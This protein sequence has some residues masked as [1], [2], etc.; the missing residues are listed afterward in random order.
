MR[1]IKFRAWDKKRNI[2]I[3]TS[4]PENWNDD[5]DEWYCDVDMMQMIGIENISNDDNFMLEQFTE[6]HLL[7]MRQIPCFPSIAYQRLHDVTV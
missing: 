6:I 4:Y 5:K 7:H 3:G 1:E 2:Y